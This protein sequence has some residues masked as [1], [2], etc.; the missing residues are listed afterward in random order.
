MGFQKATMCWGRSVPFRVWKLPSLDETVNT[1]LWYNM[2]SPRE[3][4]GE[5]ESDF[6]SACGLTNDIYLSG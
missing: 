2:L 1:A 6:R 4:L 3:Q 5:G